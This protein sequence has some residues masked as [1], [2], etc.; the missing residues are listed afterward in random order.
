MQELTEIV[1]KMKEQLVNETRI[2]EGTE[3]PE[4]KENELST[5]EENK[6]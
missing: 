4:Y 6:E 3:V 1:D 5:G 2:L